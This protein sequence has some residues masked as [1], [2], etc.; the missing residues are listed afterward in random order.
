MQKILDYLRKNPLFAFGGLV[1]LIALIWAVTY[2]H[3]PTVATQTP[4]ATLPIENVPTAGERQNQADW[5]TL[6]TLQP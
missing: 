3:R 5:D 2:C 4:K 6:K 1:A